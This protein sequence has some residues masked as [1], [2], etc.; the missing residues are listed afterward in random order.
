MELDSIKVGHCNS[1]N[2]V[3]MVLFTTPPSH[4]GAAAVLQQWQPA[5]SSSKNAQRENSHPCYP[6]PCNQCLLNFKQNEC[7]CWQEGTLWWVSGRCVQSSQWTT[8][9]LIMTSFLSLLLW[10]SFVHLSDPASLVLVFYNPLSS[11]LIHTLSS[12]SFNPNSLLV[13][14][15]IN[16]LYINIS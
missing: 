6:S 15:G 16:S 4:N 1:A 5:S 14:F 12:T 2:V 8:N 10:C 9:P 11:Y 3:V 7:L 13:S